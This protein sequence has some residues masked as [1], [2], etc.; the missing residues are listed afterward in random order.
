MSLRRSV[1][2]AVAVAT[3][4][5]AS[6]AWASPWVLKPGEYYS[7]LSGSFYSAGTY[8]RNSDDA[9]T[10]LG[11][12]LE[13]R[14]VRSHNE[15]GWKKRA[16]V[17]IDVPFVSRTWV[18]GAD[19]A[20]STGFGD[21]GLG[22]RYGMHLGK[23]PLALS[24]GWTA[25]LGTNR[26]L[27]PG[28]SGDGGLDGTS[29][30]ALSQATG[31]DSSTFLSQGM[32]SLSASLDVAGTLGKRAFYTLGGGYRTRYLTV[33]A[34]KT[35]DRY[36]DFATTDVSLGFWLTQNLMVSGAFSGEWQVSQ[37]ESY[38]RI[39]APITVGSGPELQ[40]VNMLAG[41]RVTYRIDDKMDVFAGTWHNP[42]GRNTLHADQFYCGIA[43]RQS[44][45]DRLA[46]A[47]GGTKAH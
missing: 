10:S 4:S 18:S 5:L 3:V 31:R 16:S 11:G 6:A 25:P 15:L 30:G 22:V 43:W 1:A 39:S 36:A 42:S 17:W 12:T 32:Q 47:F 23:A 38:D 14:L 8:Y 26:R 33:G 20:T 40:S 24:L 7:E 41:E 13:Q 9:R 2:A 37:G 45:L 46:G 34:R 29:F 35:T 27:F 28:T 19:D 21:I 44:A